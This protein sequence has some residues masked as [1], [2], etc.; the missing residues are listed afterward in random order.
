VENILKEPTARKSL[1]QMK[2]LGILDVVSDMVKEVRPLR[3]YLA[4]QLKKNR[5]VGL[6]LDLMDL[7]V[8][9]DTP[10]TG[11]KLDPKQL[12]R[13]REITIGMDEKDASKYLD[14]LISPPIDNREIFE[15]LNLKGSERSKMKPTAQMI[16]LEIPSLATNPRKLTNEVIK[17][18]R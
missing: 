13:F 9:A 10:L 7:G 3:S 1:K 11:L 12:Q 17:A 6:L 2:D 4:G 14:L 8:P 18:L 16:L 5:Q 15:T